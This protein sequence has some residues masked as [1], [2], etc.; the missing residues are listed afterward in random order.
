MCFKACPPLAMRLGNRAGII[1]R[2]R[3]NL[4]LGLVLERIGGEGLELSTRTSS[5][6]P[7]LQQPSVMWVRE[8]CLSGCI[9]RVTMPPL[10]SE[11]LTRCADNLSRSI[12]PRC[13]M[14]SSSMG[15][16]TSGMRTHAPRRIDATIADTR[17]TVGRL[18]AVT[19]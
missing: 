10:S 2:G 6:W 11:V 7:L 5:G 4:P 18:Q 16:T 1:G 9:L 8:M 17:L 12:V 13:H 3:V 15:W 14:A 19:K